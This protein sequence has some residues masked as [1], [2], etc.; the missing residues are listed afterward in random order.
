MVFEQK[1]YR[2]PKSDDRGIGFFT[3]VAGA[4]ADRNLIDLY[5]D[6][7]IEFIGLSD[8]RPDDKFGIAAG[9]AHVSKRAQAL[10]AG[11]RALVNPN[12]PMRNVEG[13]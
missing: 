1:L 6:T 9:Y 13:L 12:W 5:A 8:A 3:R 7:G 2:I 10:D 11:Y 4:P